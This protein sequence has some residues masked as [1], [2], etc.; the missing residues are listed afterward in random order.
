VHFGEGL[1]NVSI[2]TIR[3][4]KIVGAIVRDMFSPEVRSEE[5]INRVNDVIDE[6][7][8]LVQQIGFI[9]GEGAAKTEKMLNSII[10]SYKTKKK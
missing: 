9:L 8:S 1:L 10:E 7:L 5:V 2:F 6:N 4:D 3:K